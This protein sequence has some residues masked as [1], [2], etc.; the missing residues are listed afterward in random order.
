MG[1]LG[2]SCL[3]RVTLSTSNSSSASSSSSTMSPLWASIVIRFMVATAGVAVRRRP[4]RL[5]TS[6][7]VRVTVSASNP[8]SSS[9]SSSSSTISSLWVGMT[10]RFMVA[11]AGVAVRCRPR[12][13]GDLGTSCLLRVTLSASN[14]SS[15]SS[16]SS[17][18]FSTISSL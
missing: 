5:G 9:S 16:S 11:T 17:S 7:L 8:S 12:R 14:S 2:T 1:D 6:C 4:R 13:M 3:L 18:S 10:I 15:S